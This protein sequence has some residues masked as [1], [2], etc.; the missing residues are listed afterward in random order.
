MYRNS[1]SALHSLENDIV[2]RFRHTPFGFIH[3]LG[4]PF[5]RVEEDKFI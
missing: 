1:R 5:R 4:L 3:K 2:K